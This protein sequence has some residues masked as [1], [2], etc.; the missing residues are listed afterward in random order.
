[1]KKNVIVFL[2]VIILIGLLTFI[3]GELMSV[4]SL[5]WLRIGLGVIINL[6][7]AVIAY[8]AIKVTEI[9][10]DFEWKN[11]KQYIYGLVI[12]IG[13]SLLIAWLPALLG[14]SLVGEHADFIAWKFIYYFCNYL[15]IIGPV[16]ELI[17]RV[18]IQETLLKFCKKKKWIGVLLASFIFGLWHL[19]NG[20]FIQVLFT[21]GIGSVF[22]FAKEY[23]KDMHY[24]G[25]AFSHGL[26]DFL[27]YIVRLTIL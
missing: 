21:F 20:S 5:I 7:N 24:P 11:Y 14:M 2:I 19:I 25:I 3:Y 13:L 12:C 17:F 22:G 10:I 8:V 26:Y 4:I 15:L 6:L 9:K 16:E 23:I 18:Y 27:N 1:M